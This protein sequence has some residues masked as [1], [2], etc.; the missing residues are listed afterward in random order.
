[1]SNRI[2]ALVAACALGVSGAAT[3]PAWSQTT[4]RV[5]NHSDLKILDP[6]WTTAYIVRNHG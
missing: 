2:L 5:V 1:M 4:L 6:I 3:A